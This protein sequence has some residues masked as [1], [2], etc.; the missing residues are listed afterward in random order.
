M[1]TV[2][3]NSAAGAGFVPA[4][5]A[6]ETRRALN[7]HALPYSFSMLIG[8]LSVIGLARLIALAFNATD[9]FTDEAQ[10]WSWSRELALGYYSKPPLIAWIIAAAEPVCG[11]SEYC[12]R[13]PSVL[14]HLATSIVIYLIGRRL[15]SE[16][17]G[18]WSAITFAT[19]PGISLSSGI[20]STDVPLLFAWAVA[21]LAFAELVIV[22]STSMAIL[23]GLALGV[24]LNAKYAMAYFVVCAAVFF[25]IAPERR[26]ILRQHY[27]GLSLAITAALVT[28]NILWN[29][30]HGFSTF[31]HTADNAN[32]TG[33]LFHPG[34]A[35]E[36]IASQ[37]GVFGPIMFAALMLIGARA[38][39]DG[40]R[41]T[42]ASTRGEE[43][44]LIA[45]SLPVVMI[46]V[47]QALLSR[48]LANWAAPAYVAG[49]VLVVGIMVREGSWKWL[50]S[51]LAINSL[52]GVGLAVAT[53]VAGS[54]IL[55]NG[56][57]PFARTLGNRALAEAVREGLAK[58]A[59]R[60]V[61]FG[62][63]L[64]DD[65]D[66][67]AALLY[68]GRDIPLPVYAWRATERPRNHFELK[69]PFTAGVPGPVLLVSRR[70]DGSRIP[71]RFEHAMA[72][73]EI[74]VPTGDRSERHFHL[75]ELDGLKRK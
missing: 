22:P 57:Q 8:V 72:L 5:N 73:G 12:V 28:P 10:Y 53:A 17:V 56:E 64:T 71:A 69:Q 2:L 63:L 39:V 54:V 7:V 43:R 65:R 46:L 49:T 74:R 16:R 47:I 66:T 14:I 13:L 58:N 37:F 21:L 32:W 45:F 4:R 36:F 62:A 25:L 9:L 26:A 68:Y 3:S 55:P 31:A 75:F 38:L 59:D 24:G 50:R 19:L 51:S 30:G 15:I 41:G 11:D 70:A 61:H 67:T 33:T 42:L 44:L 27:L 29:I 6:A 34:R 18:F 23:L 48:S 35:V 1:A 40:R 52:I 60:D 20:I